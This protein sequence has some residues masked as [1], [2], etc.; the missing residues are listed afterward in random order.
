MRENTGLV[1]QSQ[2]VG[3]NAARAETDERPAGELGQ[4]AG[5]RLGVQ[6][7]RQVFRRRGLPDQGFL[8]VL[9]VG[10]G[11]RYHDFVVVAL[12]EARLVLGVSFQEI[13]LGW[14]RLAPAAVGCYFVCA[15]V[16][17]LFYLYAKY[18]DS[19]TRQ[20]IIGTL[21][22]CFFFIYFNFFIYFFSITH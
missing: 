17:S 19:A 15:N 9:R 11:H 13:A 18:Y 21:H 10:V 16:L 7:P 5:R 4:Q 14:R 3:V 12:R 8:L 22:E 1:L 20:C 2:I 6:H